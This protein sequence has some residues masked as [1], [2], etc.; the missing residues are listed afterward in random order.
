MTYAYWKAGKVDEESCFDLFFRKCP[1]NGEFC[2][3]AGLDEIL[4]LLESFKF[5]EDD[6]EYLRTVLPGAEDEF[7]EW[8]STLGAVYFHFLLLPFFPAREHSPV[9]MYSLKTECSFI[10]PPFNIISFLVSYSRLLKHSC[11]CS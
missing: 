10:D 11:V 4:P 2:I 9:L 8:L 6:I 7:F 3:F 5:T 1:F